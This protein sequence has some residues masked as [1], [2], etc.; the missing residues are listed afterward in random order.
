[1]CV[2]D[3]VRYPLR[4]ALLSVIEF[5]HPRPSGA[6]EGT[7]AKFMCFTFPQPR[8]VRRCIILRPLIPQCPSLVQNVSRLVVSDT[9]GFRAHQTDNA[10]SSNSGIHV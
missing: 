6:L 4:N 1:M 9:S 3:F 8:Q 5:E 7:D 2:R 10:Q